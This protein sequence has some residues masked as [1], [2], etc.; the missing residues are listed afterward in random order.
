MVT[1]GVVMSGAEQHQLITPRRN[2]LIRALGFTAAGVTMP[3]PIIT[4]AD[5]KT[6][7]EH[8]KRGLCDA[9]RDYY[10]GATCSVQ[11]ND[12]EPHFVVSQRGAGACLMFYASAG[13]DAH[14]IGGVL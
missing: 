5:A 7:I 10:A 14:K 3:I 11:G 8:H 2:F 4:L 1:A 12:M 9:W 6:R 13:P